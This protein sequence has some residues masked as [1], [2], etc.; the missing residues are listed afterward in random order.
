MAEKVKKSCKL[1]DV[2]WK[3]LAKKEVKPVIGYSVLGGVFAVVLLIGLLCAL[4]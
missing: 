3:E 4:V 1:K 2:N